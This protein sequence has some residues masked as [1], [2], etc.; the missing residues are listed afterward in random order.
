MQGTE[1]EQAAGP[2]VAGGFYFYFYKNT[3]HKHY[4][5]IFDRTWAFDILLSG[6]VVVHMGIGRLILVG[7]D[8]E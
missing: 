1:S 5:L 8:A 7:L 3:K 4:I 2:V 6:L